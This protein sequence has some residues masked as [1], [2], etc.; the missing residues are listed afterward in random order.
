M[1]HRVPGDSAQPGSAA[2]G[3]FGAGGDP[4]CP[5]IPLPFPHSSPLHVVWMFCARL[6][7][8]R[9]AGRIPRAP[10]QHP[11]LPW[12]GCLRPAACSPCSWPS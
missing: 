11:D 6:Q 10:S 1:L 5:L 8:H 3:Q 2:S 7:A 4:S 9:E 12:G